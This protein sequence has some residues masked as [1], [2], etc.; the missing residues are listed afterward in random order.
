MQR[1]ANT[2]APKSSIGMHRATALPTVQAVAFIHDP[3]NS[4]NGAMTIF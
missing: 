3:K 2:L 1:F 4:I